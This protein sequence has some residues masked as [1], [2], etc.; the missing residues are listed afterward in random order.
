MSFAEETTTLM[1]AERS[2]ALEPLSPSEVIGTISHLTG[3]KVRTVP[4]DSLPLSDRLFSVEDAYNLALQIGE[5]EKKKIENA[6]CESGSGEILA[7]TE[8]RVS[9]DEESLSE[10]ALALIYRGNLYLSQSRIESYLSCPF[11]YF[12][13]YNLKLGENEK[14]ELS[15]SVIGSFL[16]SI[17]ENFFGEIRDSGKRVNEITDEEKLRI[18][19]RSAAR[20]IK[21]TLGD[22]YGKERTRVAIKRLCR[23]ASPVIDGICDE[24]SECKFEPTLFELSTDG[25]SPSDARPIVYECDGGSKIIIRGRVDRVDTYHEGENVY[26]RV[27]DYK[28]GS[29][30]F[31][32]RDLERGINMQMFL[33][34]KSIVDTDSPE[35]RERIGAKDGDKLIPAGVIYAKASVKDAVVMHS[36]DEEAKVRAKEESSREGMILDD[37]IS[38]SAMNPRFTPLKYPETSRNKLSNDEKKYTLEGWDNIVSGMETTIR[39]ISDKMHS[40]N[41]NAEP[42]AIHK[43]DPCEFCSY[44][45]VCRKK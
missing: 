11:S 8:K 30:E 45:A 25:K 20:Y 13:K 42:N 43:F 4:I 9:N 10:E 21:D 17:L 5:D 6:L 1:W 2:A 12:L 34:L 14:A 41:I 37:D 15:P 29:K 22:G 23:A 44:R 24:F 27:V 3:G 31:S 32:P 18:T 28:T 38:L 40:G 39:D 7:K 19:E 36:S 35:F 26:V 33:Y 16:H